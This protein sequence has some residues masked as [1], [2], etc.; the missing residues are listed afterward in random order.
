MNWLRFAVKVLIHGGLDFCGRPRRRRDALRGHLIVLTYHSF[1]DD[2][3]QG[4]FGSLP[5][6]QF[7]RQLGFLKS[8]FELVS[9]R[10]GLESIRAGWV[11][12]RPF[13]ALTIDD[14]FEDNY[15]LA[16][17]LLR[18]YGVPATIFLATDFI[19]S[20]RPPWPTRI[21]EML[22]Q[23]PLEEMSFPF[24]ARLD[25]LPGKVAV[26][27]RLQRQLA[28]LLPAERLQYLESLRAHLCVPA[29]W[30]CRA[31][32]WSQVREMRDHG[33][34]FG[35]H[36]AF[37]SYLPSSSDEVVREE[38]RSSKRRIEDELSEP[39]L[40]FAYP[41]GAYDD[42]AIDAVRTE[43][44]EAAVTQVRGSNIAATPPHALHRIE[45]PYHDPF[46][47]FRCRTALAL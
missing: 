3:S 26:A 37:H 46:A 33:I 11:K 25:S 47:T 22:D 43:G 24:A 8:R 45:V 9:L 44:Y 1:S 32:S 7:E 6:R 29:G 20:G 41:D 14:G 39:C 17:P 34:H 40:T 36:T 18:R 16:W 23:T 21:V 28:P 13:L 12:E 30:R 19:D 4:I 10:E 27:R 5:V 15:T 31:L 38:L 2:W 42:R 35:S